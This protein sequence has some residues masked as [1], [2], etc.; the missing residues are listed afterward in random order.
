M[1]PKQGAK[2]FSRFALYWLWYAFEVGEIYFGRGNNTTIPNLSQS[3]L[4]ELPLPVPPLDEQ[5][6]IAAVLGLVQRAIEQQERL[7]ALTGELKRALMHKLFT[8]GL[9]GEPR[10]Q[11]EIGPVPESWTVRRV[12][13]IARL[14]SGGTPS[15]KNPE[16]WADGSI[17]WVKTGEIDYRIIRATE[18]S[19]TPAGPANSSAKLFPSGTLLMAMY[20]QGVTRGKVGILG[21]EAATNQACVAFFPNGE[22]SSQFLRYYFEHHYDA[23]RTL[24]HGANQKNLSAEILRAFPIA[25]PSDDQGQLSI[26]EP[27]EAIVRRLILAEHKRLLLSD[28]FRTLLHQLMTAQIRVHDL[29]LTG[30]EG[31]IGGEK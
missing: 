4:R 25:F 10:K 3:T 29:D 23:I 22:V 1:R 13:E 21:I 30:I 7:I 6:K 18:E 12:G 26:V 31:V 20:G 16:Y 8:E 19:I 17:L 27:L 28:L 5:R 2:V 11:T 15:R 14:Q 9:R 24:G